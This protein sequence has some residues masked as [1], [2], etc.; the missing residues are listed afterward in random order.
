LFTTGVLLSKRR[1]DPKRDPLQ[2]S[3]TSLALFAMYA[4]GADGYNLFAI[5]E[6]NGALVSRDSNGL[7]AP[8]WLDPSNQSGVKSRDGLAVALFP[9]CV[10]AQFAGSLAFVFRGN[11]ISEDKLSILNRFATTIEAVQAL[12]HTTASLAARIGTLDAEL[13]GIKIAERTR[14]ILTGGMPEPEAIETLVSH[15]ER[16]LEGRQFG[17]ALQQLLPDLEDQLATR[18][19]VIR[20]KALLESRH[21]MSEEQAYFHLRVK[22]RSTRRRL[23]EVAQELL[24]VEASARQEERSDVHS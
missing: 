12:P 14:G 8:Q 5:D 6:A 19:A 21:G 10:D 7:A 1:P 16:V 17:S 15:V 9:L 22:S 13:A 2:Q 24:A 20:A 4:A 23:L 11:D 18:R 3:V